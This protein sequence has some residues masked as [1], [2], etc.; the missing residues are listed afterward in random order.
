MPVID[1]W[2]KVI[3][4]S[5]LMIIHCLSQKFSEFSKSTRT[6]DSL[7]GRRISQSKTPWHPE[8]IPRSSSYHAREPVFLSQSSWE[9]HTWYQDSDPILNVLSCRFHTAKKSR[10]ETPKNVYFWRPSIWS[11]LFVYLLTNLGLHSISSCS[12]ARQH[13]WW[14]KKMSLP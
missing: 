11:C 5:G 1:L 4:T 10:R 14:D 7:K 2:K 12:Y 8:I 13:F 9:M 6:V 3:S